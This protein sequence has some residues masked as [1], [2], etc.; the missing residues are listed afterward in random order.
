M[1]NAN[2]VRTLGKP[3]SNEESMTTLV[4]DFAEDGGSIGSLT[5]GSIGRKVILTRAIVYVESACTSGGS[6]T[7]K[8]GPTTADDDAMLTTTNGAVANLT[9]DASFKQAATEG[10]VVDAGDTI[11]LVIATAALTAGKI[12][13]KVFYI[14]A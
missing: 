12:L 4:Y 7:V 8:I 13:V 5:L 10:L 6:A 11:D 1:A 2:T 9:A 14:D 3:A